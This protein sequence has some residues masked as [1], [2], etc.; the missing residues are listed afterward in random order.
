M[1]RSI[2]FTGGNIDLEFVRKQEISG[3]DKIICADRGLE[4]VHCLGLVPDVLVGDFD[5]VDPEILAFYEGREEVHIMRYR[6]EK[7][8]TDTELALHMAM[9]QKP[10]EILVFGAFGTRLDHTLANIG[11]LS[12][13]LGRGIPTYLCDS[14]NKI[15]MIKDRYCI[16][17]ERAFGDYITLLP[18]GGNAGGV[19]LRGFRY[20]LT[21]AVMYA[22]SSLGVS[23]ELTGEQGVI[24]V[25]TG[26]L[27]VMES[28]D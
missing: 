26:K 2:V 22:G 10:D 12:Q 25:K 6:P 16:L 20:P 7:D 18:F 19:T 13:A 21:D 3:S 28:R 9:E 1:K 4:T 15:C 11:L 23:N 8:D 27:L 5:S 17:R 24:E 14:H